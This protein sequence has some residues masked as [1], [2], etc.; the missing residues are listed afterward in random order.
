MKFI[1]EEVHY[2]PTPI[3]RPTFSIRWQ[4]G[5]T[6]RYF[7]STYPEFPDLRKYRPSSCRNNAGITM[8]RAPPEWSKEDIFTS[9]ICNYIADPETPKSESLVERLE[10]AAE[11]ICQETDNYCVYFKY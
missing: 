9:N 4:T 1:I 2:Y 7:W 11:E 5:V 10:K 3:Q 8:F 6:D